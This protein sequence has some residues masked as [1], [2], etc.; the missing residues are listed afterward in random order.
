MLKYN[1]SGYYPGIPTRDLTDEEV[2]KY[3]G[4]KFLLSLKIYEKV[5]EP[6]KKPVKE[7]DNDTGN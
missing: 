3:G 7:A 6:V 1:G 5:K 2:E 4:E